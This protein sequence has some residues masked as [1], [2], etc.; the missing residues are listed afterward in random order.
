[1]NSPPHPTPPTENSCSKSGSS[2]NKIQLPLVL[3]LL[4]LGLW[5]GFL[6]YGAYLGIS[7]QA[8]SHDPR[9]AWIMLICVGS[10][11]LFWLTALALRGKRANQPS[12][13]QPN[14]PKQIK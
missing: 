10:F 13:S 8:P 5:G 9:R 11:L 6:A 4:G 12:G 7:D 14:K 1:M 3:I 2:E